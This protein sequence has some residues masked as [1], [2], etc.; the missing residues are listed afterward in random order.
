MTKKMVKLAGYM[1]RQKKPG[2]IFLGA[3]HAGFALK[4]AIKSFLI[5][6]DYDVVDFGA[7]EYVGDDDYPDFIIPTVEAAVKAKA[8]A[9]VFGG[10]GIGECIAANKVRGSRCALVYDE[11]T[12]RL[13]REHNDANVLSLGGRTRTKSARLAKRLVQVWL[14]TE[15]SDD[16]RHVRRLRKITKHEKQ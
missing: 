16:P 12:A 1:K 5:D 6:L 11:M 3:D 4:E 14:M 2:R 8:R 10:S 15:F 13:S 7:A 9:I